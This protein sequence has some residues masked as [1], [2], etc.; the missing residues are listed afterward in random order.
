MKSSKQGLTQD[1]QRQAKTDM[2]RLTKKDRQAKTD[3][4]EQKTYRDMDT[5]NRQADGGVPDV[6]EL[7]APFLAF[8][9]GTRDGVQAFVVQHSG[10]L[11]QVVA[12]CPGSLPVKF[13]QYKNMAVLTGR[14]TAAS[15]GG[16]TAGE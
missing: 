8:L 12:D 13:L 14:S 4:Q 10:N 16:T 2:E 3:T 5:E 6:W 15:L 9:L 7:G 11:I 1:R